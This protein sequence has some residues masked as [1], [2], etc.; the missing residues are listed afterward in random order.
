MSIASAL[1]KRIGWNLANNSCSLRRWLWDEAV[2]LIVPHVD[3]PVHAVRVRLRVLLGLQGVHPVQFGDSRGGISYGFG[4]AAI[5][6]CC[7]LSCGWLPGYCEEKKDSRN[8]DGCSHPA[9]SEIYSGAK[10]T[11]SWRI[12][13]PEEHLVAAQ[14]R[15][16]FLL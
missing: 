2:L 7:G 11:E 6:L 5:L 8:K 15:A 9:A 12:A 4:L 16:S 14:V 13:G 1:M 10:Q 3:A